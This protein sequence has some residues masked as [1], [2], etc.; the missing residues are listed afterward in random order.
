MFVKC[1][2]KTILEK[3]VEFILN[4]DSI[5]TMEKIVD[6]NKLNLHMTTGD[7][8]F[9]FDSEEIKNEVYEA[10]VELLATRETV[11]SDNLSLLIL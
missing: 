9:W 7:Y 6:E 11:L 3:P 2:V 1:K 5:V 8:D 4:L 10:F